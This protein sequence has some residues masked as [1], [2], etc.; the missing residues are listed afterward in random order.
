[1]Q[2][3][4]SETRKRAADNTAPVAQRKPKRA[5]AGMQR[6]RLDE[7]E[8]YGGSRSGLN[9]KGSADGSDGERPTTTTD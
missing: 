5:K 6:E 3:A 2:Q 7:S 1:M 9:R 4:M 8:S